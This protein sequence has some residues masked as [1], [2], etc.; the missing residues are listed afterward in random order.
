MSVEQALSHPFL[1]PVR[2]PN[3]EV[4]RLEGPLHFNRV[5]ADNIRDL[6]VEE[7]RT[8]NAAI[9]DNWKELAAAQLYHGYPTSGGY[10]PQ[11]GDS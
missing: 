4:G 3:D 2:R 7:I 11:N 10:S 8:Y 1:V 6:I 9:P 5:D